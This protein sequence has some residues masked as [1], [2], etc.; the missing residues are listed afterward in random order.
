M[1]EQLL[2]IISVSLIILWAS[3]PHHSVRLK[4]Y[5][6]DDNEFWNFNKSYLT[7]F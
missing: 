2:C 5:A 7:K 1:L 4:A 6:I 3:F